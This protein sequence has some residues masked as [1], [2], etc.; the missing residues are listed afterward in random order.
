VRFSNDGPE[1]VNL[2]SGAVSTLHHSLAKLHQML[3]QSLEPQQ[4]TKNW[5]LLFEP[6]SFFIL[7]IFL[8]Q[9]DLIFIFFFTLN[10]FFIFRLF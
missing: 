4:N 8:K 5:M 9:F 2:S 7:K 10:Y 3:I 1:G 6:I